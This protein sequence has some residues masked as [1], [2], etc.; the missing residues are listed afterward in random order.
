MR[1]N[2]LLLSGGL[3]VSSVPMALTAMAGESHHEEHVKLDS[4]PAPARAA[5]LREA[6]GAPVLGVEIEKKGGKTLYEAHV[7]QGSE[8]IG[9]VV[10]EKGTLIGKHSEKDEDEDHEHHEH[11]DP[12]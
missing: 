8:V 9:I 12:K 6:K 5:I 1:I 11:H 2:G 3:L 10:D 4:I 7:K